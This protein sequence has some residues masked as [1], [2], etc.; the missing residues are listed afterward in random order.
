MKPE[1][2][3]NLY[4]YETSAGGR[5]FPISPGEPI[6]RCPAYTQKDTSAG[7]WTC[8]I[9]IGEK[10]MEPGE[11][12]VVGASFLV[13]EGLELVIS[14]GKFYLW[15]GRFTGEANIIGPT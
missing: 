12:R 5:Q 4:L 13:K 10:P 1:L 3:A 6:F 9:D 8:F 15:E 2:T 14:A 11:A 7:G